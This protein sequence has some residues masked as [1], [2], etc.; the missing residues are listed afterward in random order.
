MSDDAQSQE[1]QR[2]R[3]IAAGLDPRNFD[4]RNLD[5]RRAIDPAHLERMLHAQNLARAQATAAS[6][7]VIATMVS[8][9]TSA[10]GFVAAL[11][12]NNAIQTIIQENENS[13]ALEKAL[14]LTP[15]QTELVYAAVVTLIAVVVV[16]VINRIA[17]GIAKNSVLNSGN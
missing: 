8:L 10:F 7:V 4:P 12:W 3:G 11:A 6:T 5:P 9:V 17:K 2:R 1:Q 13:G 14:H 15:G 16:V